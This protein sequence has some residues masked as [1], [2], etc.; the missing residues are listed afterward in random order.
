MTVCLSKTEE[1]KKLYEIIAEIKSA[2]LVE[3]KELER[4]I[5]GPRK[6]LKEFQEDSL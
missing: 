5:D 2:N 3:K 4:I 6:K 1:I